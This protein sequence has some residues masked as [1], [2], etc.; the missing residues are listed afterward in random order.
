MLVN[1]WA[2]FCCRA[3]R[4]LIFTSHPMTYF[5][6][7]LLCTRYGKSKDEPD[8]FL[9]GY[10]PASHCWTGCSACSSVVLLVNSGLM[11]SILGWGVGAGAEEEFREKKVGVGTFSFVYKGL[12]GK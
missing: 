6:K 3:I 8:H 10:Q 7:Y 2:E 12:H 4:M 5:I 9:L 11:D 1:L